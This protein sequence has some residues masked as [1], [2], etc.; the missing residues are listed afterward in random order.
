MSREL[1]KIALG[2]NKTV[3]VHLSTPSSRNR[4]MWIYDEPG[5]KDWFNT[6]FKGLY[7]LAYDNIHR[8]LGKYVT[9]F[10]RVSTGS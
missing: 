3:T 2:R 5:N 6:E 1:T 10:F 9:T 8:P 4:K 7:A